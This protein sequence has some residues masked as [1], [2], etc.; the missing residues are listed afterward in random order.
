MVSVAKDV[1]HSLTVMHPEAATLLWWYDHAIEE[2]PHTLPAGQ[3]DNTNECRL[4]TQCKQQHVACIAARE[5]WI[6]MLAALQAVW[7]GSLQ[8]LMVV[9]ACI[10]PLLS[11]YLLMLLRASCPPSVSRALTAAYVGARWAN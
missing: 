1:L 3:G 10:Q 5:S 2:L 9:F 8:Q 11:T 6:C 4:I 7:P